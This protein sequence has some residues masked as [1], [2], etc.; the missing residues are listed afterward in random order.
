MHQLYSRSSPG[1]GLLVLAL[2]LKDFRVSDTESYKKLLKKM[3][4]NDVNNIFKEIECLLS[5]F[6]ILT[7]LQIAEFLKSVEQLK[8]FMFLLESFSLV[9]EK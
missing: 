1:D 6:R 3:E 9:I 7:L 8:A 4:V 5:S 2:L